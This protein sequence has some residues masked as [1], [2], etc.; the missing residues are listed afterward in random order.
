MTLPPISISF[1]PTPAA[2]GTHR[3]TTPRPYAAKPVSESESS[4]A[5]QV[6]TATMNSAT[7]FSAASRRRVSATFWMSAEASELTRYTR[8]ALRKE[9]KA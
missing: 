2:G 9:A 5:S 1:S 6:R 7:S 4:T 8:A 3:A